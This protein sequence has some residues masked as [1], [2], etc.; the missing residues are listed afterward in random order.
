MQL[1]KNSKNWAVIHDLRL[2]H[3]NQV[4]QIDHLMI[5]RSFDFYV[6]ESKNYAY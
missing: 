1:E 2:E 5:N 6:L 3:E 4:A